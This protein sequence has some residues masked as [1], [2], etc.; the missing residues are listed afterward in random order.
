MPFSTPRVFDFGEDLRMERHASDTEI[1]HTALRELQEEGLETL[2][3][4]NLETA[5]PEWDLTFK[6]ASG[7]FGGA[8]LLAVDPVGTL[9]VFELKYGA[10]KRT[11][12]MQAVAYALSATTAPDWRG[13]LSRRKSLTAEFV[14]RRAAGVWHNTRTGTL[15]GGG[16]STSRDKD[17]HRLKQVAPDE[18]ANF[19]ALGE[20]HAT[21]I[22]GQRPNPLR[23]ILVAPA[24]HLHVVTPGVHDGVAS[25]AQELV[26]RGVPVSLWSATVSVD[27]DNRRGRLR[28]EPVAVAISRKGEKEPHLYLDYPATRFL[29]ACIK[30]SPL[31]GRFHWERSASSFRWVD[32]TDCFDLTVHF[33]QG[34]PEIYFGPSVPPVIRENRDRDDRWNIQYDSDRR[35][36]SHFLEAAYPPPAGT[37]PGLGQLGKKVEYD[38]G[39]DAN[40]VSIWRNSGGTGLAGAIRIKGASSVTRAAL[41]EYARV[42]APAIRDLIDAVESARQRGELQPYTTADGV[43]LGHLSWADDDAV[44]ER[45]EEP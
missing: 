34:F 14:G 45:A 30:V 4:L 44:E 25:E 20:A 29:A 19:R 31:L 18:W 5:F 43:P 1:G 13:S 11:S 16:K 24:V 17:L 12:L 38:L 36:C 8:D 9:H 37:S 7:A 32:P 22:N 27:S 15:P 33:W 28:L 39:P 41:E 6:G 42:L 2:L 40:D 35:F 3:M 21:R 10:S 26:S 23:G